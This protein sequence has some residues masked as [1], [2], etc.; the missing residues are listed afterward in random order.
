M[1]EPS[2]RP[3]SPLS[4]V[5]CDPLRCAV[6]HSQVG[7]TPV[8]VRRSHQVLDFLWEIGHASP[9]PISILIAF[10][11]M[12]SQAYATDWSMNGSSC[13]PNDTTIQ[14]N[15]YTITGGTVTHKGNS[16]DL[17]ILYCPIAGVSD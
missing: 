1:E 8:Q 7:N 10:S 11:A 17:I 3:F 2:A 12:S 15:S 4:Q 6:G 13:V 14:A 9:Y 5:E 16:T